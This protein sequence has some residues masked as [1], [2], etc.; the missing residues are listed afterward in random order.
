MP[1][2]EL[3]RTLPRFSRSPTD[4]LERNIPKPRTGMG[5]IHFDVQ[6]YFEKQSHFKSHSGLSVLHRDRVRSGSQGYEKLSAKIWSVSPGFESC[7]C[8]SVTVSP[9]ARYLSLRL[10][11]YFFESVYFPLRLQGENVLGT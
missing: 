6:F 11:S 8:Y 4:V 3:G 7:L 5:G 1:V 9:M 2:K 10:G